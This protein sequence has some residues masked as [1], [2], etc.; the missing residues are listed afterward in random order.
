MKSHRTT[1]RGLA[2]TLALGFA[3]AASAAPAE[4]VPTQIV[5]PL[6]GP[7]QYF[8]N[9]FGSPR[10]Q[11]PH[12]GDD[13]MS[14]RHAP[15]V[16]AE[17]G[18]VE[19]ET[20]SSRAGCML[21]LHGHSGTEY[22]YIHLN[23][24]LTAG[25][26]NRGTCVQ[27]VAFAKGLRSGD[28]VTAGQLV[29]YVG[30]SGDA[31]GLQ[32]HLHFEVHP[33]G[34]AAVDPYPTLQ[35]AQRLLFSVA[36]GTTFTLQLTGTMTGGDPTAKSVKVKVDSARWWPNGLKVDGVDRTIKIDT[37]IASVDSAGDSTARVAKVGQRRVT[38]MTAPMPATRDAQFG[39][40]DALVAQ[41]VLLGQ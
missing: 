12:Q 22:V 40:P 27:G 29:G 1:A 11:G 34:K 38:I 4:K 39:K 16:A 17:A 5:F 23:N 20:G 14:V 36:D 28:K 8:A 3:A 26:D 25:N 10:P 18:R 13:I 33:N 37:S 30:D 31:D 15:A 32:P 19:F 21:R 35:A 2:L 41:R 7:A 6:V 24:D 9:D